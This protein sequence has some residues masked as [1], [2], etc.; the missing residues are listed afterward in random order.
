MPIKK[1]CQLFHYHHIY[2]KLLLK[3]PIWKKISH[4]SLKG[5]CHSP[6]SCILPSTFYDDADSQTKLNVLLH[7][8]LISNIVDIVAVPGHEPFVVR[9][10]ERKSKHQQRGCKRDFWP[11]SGWGTG[12]SNRCPFPLWDHDRILFLPRWTTPCGGGSLVFFISISIL[13]LCQIKK[14]KKYSAKKIKVPP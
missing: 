12:G 10:E 1:N 9:L 3:F 4:P 7:G 13:K 14:K 6:S 5:S 2:L 8:W 11:D